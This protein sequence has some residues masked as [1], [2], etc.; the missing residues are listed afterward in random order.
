MNKRIRFKYF[1]EFLTT[2]QKHRTN[3]TLKSL[4]NLGGLHIRIIHLKNTMKK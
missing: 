4:L 1:L 2:A 3:L